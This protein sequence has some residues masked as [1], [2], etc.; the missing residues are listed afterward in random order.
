MNFCKPAA[1]LLTALLVAACQPGY[2]HES[3]E[4][5]ADRTME[6]WLPPILAGDHRSEANKHRDQYRHPLE[7]LSFFGISEHDRVIEINPGGGWYMEILAPLLFAHGQYVAATPDPRIEGLP[8]YFVAHARQIQARITEQPQLY[9]QGEVQFYDPANPVLGA[10]NSVDKVLTFRN[11]HSWINAGTAEVMFEAFADVLKPGGV[12]GVVQH[13]APEGIAPDVSAPEG[14]VSEEAVIA[15]A[16]AVG[17]RFDG[18]SEINAN[19]EDS[20]KHPYGVWT[21]PP[22]L[23]LG[24][25]QAEHYLEIGE[26]DR[27]TL[28][29]VKEEAVE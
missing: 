11:I 5:V 22:S 29:F 28:R 21:L 20:R 16:E 2:Q 8:R 17:L 13:R 26:S 25:Y 15:L 27:M 14:Y 10:P 6:L 4:T 12:L 9:G 1:V 18:S 19:P 23:R 7:T 24:D 3:V